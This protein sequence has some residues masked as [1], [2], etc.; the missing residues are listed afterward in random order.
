MDPA[1]GNCYVHDA[2]GAPTWRV[3]HGLCCCSFWAATPAVP[4]L[5]QVMDVEGDGHGENSCT[6]SFPQ[7]AHS[8]PKG[9][10]CAKVALA[11]TGRIATKDDLH[12]VF[13]NLKEMS[14]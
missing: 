12:M 9:G 13:R 5:S 14:T 1:A 6:K 4:K 11:V 10:K 8:A 2:S 7:I 3:D